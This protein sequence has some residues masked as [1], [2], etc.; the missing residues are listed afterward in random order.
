[1]K[2][3]PATRAPTDTEKLRTLLRATRY[4]LQLLDNELVGAYH[5][6]LATKRLKTALKKVTNIH[7]ISK[8]STRTR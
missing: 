3:D 1:M 4:A 2:R 6:D 7:A 8:T 5:V